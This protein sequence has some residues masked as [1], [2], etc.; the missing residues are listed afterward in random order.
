[1]GG[2]TLMLW[3]STSCFN[4]SIDT[5]AHRKRILQVQLSAISK[6]GDIQSRL[7]A[8]RQFIVSHKTD[9]RFYG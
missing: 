6:A 7:F 3:N 9:N 5:D 1:M 4:F 8:T 2:H